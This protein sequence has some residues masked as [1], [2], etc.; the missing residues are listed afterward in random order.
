MF[1]IEMSDVVLI[2]RNEY[3]GVIYVLSF[4]KWIF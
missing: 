3:L 4:E 1:L 2:M